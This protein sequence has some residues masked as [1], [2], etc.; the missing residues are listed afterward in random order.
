MKASK[1]KGIE[2]CGTPRFETAKRGPPRRLLWQKQ[3]ATLSE[4][5]AVIQRR[6]DVVL[7]VLEEMRRKGMLEEEEW[8]CYRLTSIVRDD[9]KNIFQADQME[10]GLDMW[11]AP[12]NQ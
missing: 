1:P 3:S 2:V 4:L 5:A 10:P 8:R 12:Q 9:I 6:E 11:G 7:R